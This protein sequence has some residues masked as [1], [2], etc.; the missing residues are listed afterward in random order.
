MANTKK[1][2]N[3]RPKATVDNAINLDGLMDPQDIQKHLDAYRGLPRHYRHYGT[4]KMK[5]MKA[6]LAGQI[7]LALFLE[8]NADRHYANIPKAWR[9]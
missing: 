9:W 1:P 2:F 7:S 6:R 4:T 3:T 5:A 8:K